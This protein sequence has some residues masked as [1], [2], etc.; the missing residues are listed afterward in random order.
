VGR[1]DPVPVIAARS[2]IHDRPDPAE[3][4]DMTPRPDSTRRTPLVTALASALAV[5]ALAACGGGDASST[6]DTTLSPAAERGRV[7]A[8]NSGCASCHGPTW[9][10]G[11]APSWIGL[12]GSE[13]ELSD[14]TT[15]IADADYLTRAITAPADEKVAG[16]SLVMPANLLAAAD[17]A[18]VVAFIESLAAPT[19]DA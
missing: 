10:G 7:T 13:V 18:D 16:Y 4:T 2:T 14:G 6:P 8:L 9:A 12:A 11:V 19:D 17:V 1:L 5:V 3:V 15:V